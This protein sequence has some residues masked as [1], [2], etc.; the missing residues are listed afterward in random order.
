MFHFP[1][2]WIMLFLVLIVWGLVIAVAAYLLGA[3]IALGA[4]VAS[5]V[6]PFLRMPAFVRWSGAALIV[7]ALAVWGFP[8]TLDGSAFGNN[9]WQGTAAWVFRMCFGVAMVA[10]SVTGLVISVT[11]VAA[12]GAVKGVQAIASAV[13]DKN[14]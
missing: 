2:V 3:M 9:E 5:L 13:E 8:E 12:K 7:T 14:Q 1:V 11:K 4:W 10:L 6:L